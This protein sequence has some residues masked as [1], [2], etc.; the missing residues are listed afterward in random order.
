MVAC[1]V[2]NGIVAAFA[3]PVVRGHL[4]G[5]PEWVLTLFV[6]LF[7]L[8]GIVLLVFFVR[9]FLITTGIGPTLV[10]ISDHPLHPG[11]QC[12]LFLSQPGRLAINSIEVLLVCEEEATYRQ[13]TNTRT[14]TR[15]VCHRQLFHRDAFEVY[16]GMPFEAECELSVPAAAMHSFKAAHNGVHWKVVVKG[17]IAR[18]PDYER[19]FPVIIHPTNGSNPG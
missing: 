19:S 16:R 18:W 4:R 9:Q 8:G 10:E 3:V 5:D 11:Q 6:V 12:R 14:E 7:G 1:L 17:D 2:W 13:G 15:K